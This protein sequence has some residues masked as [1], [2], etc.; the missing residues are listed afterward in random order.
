MDQIIYQELDEVDP[1]LFI[2]ILNSE[3]VRNHLIQHELFTSENVR[4][5]IN[6]K[7]EVDSTPGCRVRA[8]LHNNEL[9]GWC[10]IQLHD[11]KFELAIVL[12]QKNWGLGKQVFLELISW[13]KEFGHKY[14]YIH[15]LKS[16]REYQF[17]R[18]LANQVFE[19]EL[20][21]SR[22]LTYEMPVQSC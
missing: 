20:F 6:G 1:D 4:L 11:G 18:E 3:K 7:L 5:W 15:L 21:G 2:P 14:V 19:S 13:A 12:N 8:V 16:R 9:T 17:L 22:F 10:G